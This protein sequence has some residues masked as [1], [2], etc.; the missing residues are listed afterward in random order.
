MRLSKWGI[1]PMGFNTKTPLVTPS[2]GFNTKNQWVSILKFD[3]FL[4]DL[5]YPMTGK[6]PSQAYMA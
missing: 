3:D 1:K 4:D 6:T 2:M 5:G